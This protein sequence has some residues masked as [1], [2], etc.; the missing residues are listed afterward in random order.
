[1]E[2]FYEELYQYLIERGIDEDEATEVVN[3]LYEDNIHEYGLI[4]EN[5]GR[6]FLNM[7]KAVG[8]MSGVLK[9]PGAK[10]AVK[11][12]VKKVQGTPVQGNLLTKKGTAQNFTGGRTPFTSTSPV[13]AASSPLPKKVA[14]SPEAPGQMRIPGM[15]DTAQTL[16]RISGKP[17]GSGGLGITMSGTTK[18][19]PRRAPKPEFGPGAVKPTS[20]AKPKAELRP[21]GVAP[22]PEFKVAKPPKPKSAPRTNKQADAEAALK[23]T[24][25]MTAPSLP[26]TDKVVDA[27]RTRSNAQKALT[28][29]GVA[30]AITGGVGLA[31]GIVD[32]ANKESAKRDAQRKT[33]L[34]QQEAETK[35]AEAPKP[36]PTGERSAEVNQEK[37][38][39]AKQEAEKTRRSKEQLSAAAKD[40]D[41]TFAAARKE[42]KK[43]FTWRGKKYNTKLKGE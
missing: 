15:S 20:Y 7:L 22:K 13:P 9:K 24:A 16:S 31:S 21:D 38:E 6:A 42:G 33:K 36:Q 4:T 14:L 32:K 12:V 18:G 27:V 40:F 39:K 43:E 1:M 19:L 28:G 30:G 25:A 3:Y 29:V 23:K 11:Q 10:K 35:A 17:M 37:Q 34:A 2:N 8:Y 5:K 26:K 41:K